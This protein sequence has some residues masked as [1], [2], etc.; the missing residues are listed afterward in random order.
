ME[1]DTFNAEYFLHLLDLLT[2]NLRALI[3][4]LTALADKFPGDAASIVSLVEQRITKI[5]PQYKLFAFYLM[6]SIVK[7]IG[8]PYNVLFAT[9][10][11]RNFTETYL[12]VTD[13]LTRQNLINLFKT[14]LEAK[15]ASGADLFPPDTLLKLEQFIIRATSLH[16]ESSPAPRVNKDSLLREGNYLLQYVIALDEALD[17]FVEKTPS[18]SVSLKL[19]QFRKVRNGL[20][21]DINVVSEEVMAASR[22]DFEALKHPAAEKLMQLR[23]ALDDQTFQQQALMSSQSQHA[24]PVHLSIDVK[25][26]SINVD[27][28]LGD[29]AE[30]NAFVSVWGLPVVHE[31]G[32]ETRQP[33]ETTV[34]TPEHK[35][36]EPAPVEEPSLASGLGFDL[37]GFSFQ[38]STLMGSPKNEITHSTIYQTEAEDEDGYDPESN[39]IG[40]EQPDDLW[41]DQVA[42]SGVSE[43]GRLS[44]GAAVP[45]NSRTAA[46]GKSSMKRPGTGEER[47]VKRVRFDV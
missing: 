17:E 30:F 6:D 42:A 13:T 16:S 5:F 15:T 29:S 19:S 44:D 39:F 38:E 37:P 2:L 22:D 27:E 3:T 14:W 10:L 20:I 8:N 24:E 34:A 31:S 11:Y 41:I 47:A 35:V 25:P 26:K 12:V 9:N 7:N 45:P 40:V 43:T 21:F 33:K 32:A 4:E 36:D 28:I 23:K 46:T 18:P 1:E